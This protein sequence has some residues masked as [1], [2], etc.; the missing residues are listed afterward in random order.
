MKHAMLVKDC[1]TMVTIGLQ[2]KTKQ[3]ARTKHQLSILPTLKA[4]ALQSKECHK[5]TDH[6]EDFWIMDMHF[7]LVGTKVWKTSGKHSMPETMEG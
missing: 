4:S 2:L 1:K 3:I 5:S 7:F 6:D